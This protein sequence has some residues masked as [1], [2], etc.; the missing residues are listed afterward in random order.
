MPSLRAALA[1]LAL[2]A[3]ACQKP[4]AREAAPSAASSS[5]GAGPTPSSAATPSPPQVG[6]CP[7]AIQPGV[8]LGAI[9][10]GETRE[11]LE[12]HGLPVKSTSKH[13]ST[14]FLEVGPF[15][16]E[17]CGGKVVEVWLDDLRKAPDCV[18]LGGKRLDRAVAREA[19]IAMFS[20]CKDAPPRTGGSFAECE[21]S[22]VRIGWGMGD[23]IQLRVAKKGTRLDDTCEMLLDDGK[24]VPLPVVVKTKMLQKVL[25]LD[26]LAPFWHRDQ[27]G[28]DPLK[29]IANDVV[30]DRPELTIFGSKVVYVSK[31]DAETQKLPYFELT[32]LSASATKAR[33]EFRFP[34]E[35]VIGHAEFEKRFDDWGLSARHVSER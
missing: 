9:R 10:V 6:E 25:D 15:H 24:P 34:V 4:S 7:I 35:G 33:V 19:L 23:F 11:D 27:P 8:A 12:R 21:A 28:R 17:L 1:L 5:P 13:E 31:A 26:L 3:C 20:D 18:S 2:A 29:V 32:K 16:V 22:G 30:A 14:E